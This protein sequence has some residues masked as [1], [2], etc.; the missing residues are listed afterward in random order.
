MIAKFIKGIGSNIGDLVG[1]G[2]AMINRIVEGIGN[3][4]GNVL[5]KGVEVAK[6]LMKGVADAAGDLAEAG[7]K[8]IL[9]T[10]KGIRKAVE[11]NAAPI[12]REGRG[13]A[14][15]LMNGLSQ[16]V[17]GFDI[18][19]LAN[20]IFNKVKSAINSVKKKLHIGSPS[21]MV[22]EEIGMPLVQGVAMGIE[23][24]SPEM[25]RAGDNLGDTLRKII[26]TLPNE[27]DMDVNPTITPVLDLTQVKTEAKK[28]GD[29]S[30]ATP[31][32]VAAE[33]SAARQAQ[34]DTDVD[35]E[36]GAKVFKFEQN[37]YSPEA[38]SE[39]EIYRQT[40]NQLSQAKSALGL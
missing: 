38:L 23:M 4:I 19:A 12:G 11:D 18:G 7:G 28:L 40:S 21:R 30:T 6:K 29:I 34:L 13:I 36:I 5:D 17:L 8:M 14:T 2:A 35:P 24:A 22:A 9:D 33:I 1:R 15:A 10:L 32:R 37:N 26:Q 31:I 3:N 25:L 16:G 20:Q 39:A 27:V